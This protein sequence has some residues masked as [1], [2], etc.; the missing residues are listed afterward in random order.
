M[1]TFDLNERLDKLCPTAE[2]LAEGDETARSVAAFVTWRYRE[3]LEQLLRD[4]G[5][6]IKPK[7]DVH[8][9]DVAT[10]KQAIYDKGG[11]DAVYQYEQNIKRM[12][13]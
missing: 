8:P 4:Y 6:T 12:G 5:E 13:L 7:I 11:Y 2:A 9:A 3:D 1:S 10:E